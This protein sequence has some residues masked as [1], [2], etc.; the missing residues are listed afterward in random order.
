MNVI[1]DNQG[2]LDGA[3]MKYFSMFSGIGGFEKG[4]CDAFGDQQFTEE[5]QDGQGGYGVVGEGG[6]DVLFAG[7]TSTLC[8]GFSEIDKNA[9]NIY[10]YH[11]GDRT[12][13]YCSDCERCGKTKGELLTEGEGAIGQ[14]C[15]CCVNCGQPTS[16]LRH[17]K[18]HHNYGSAF[19]INPADL[20]DFDLLIGG[21]PCQAFSIAGKRLGFDDTRGTLFFEIARI[22]KHKQPS[23]F[24]LENVKGLLSHDDGKTFRTIISTLAEMGYSVEWEVLNSKNF[25]VPQNRERVFIHG[26]REGSGRQIFPLGSINREIVGRAEEASK[27]IDPKYLM[28]DCRIT[29]HC[30]TMAKRDYKEPFIVAQDIKATQGL[31]DAQRVREIDGQAVTLKGLGGGQG[32]KTGLYDIPVLTPDRPEKRQNG[33]RFKENGDEA[34]TCTA[35]DKHG[36]FDGYKIRRLTPVECERLQGFPDDWTKYGEDGKVMSDSALYK[37]CGNAVTTNVI[38]AIMEEMLNAEQVF[39]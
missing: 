27:I 13:G 4:I 30:P 25:G 5:Q 11:Y 22:L 12:N 33:R 7:R 37:A 1:I 17:I 29:E 39:V 6:S 16:V 14:D 3:L 32:A 23:Q 35:Q 20:P 24:L 8:V 26:F 2:N 9:I 15:S 36:V 34:F 21:F 31:P 19:D 10:K 18:G 28:R 38:R